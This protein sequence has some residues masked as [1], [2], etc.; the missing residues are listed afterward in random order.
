MAKNVR[1]SGRLILDE[2]ASTN[3]AALH[4]RQ[5]C[6]PKEEY[7]VFAVMPGRNVAVVNL[8]DGSH[9]TPGLEIL[10]SELE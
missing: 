1:V 7:R 10:I 4:R 5:K 8:A 2:L 6:H 9:L 3:P